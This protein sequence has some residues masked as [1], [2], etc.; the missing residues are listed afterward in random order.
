[1]TREERVAELG[2]LQTIKEATD[3]AIAS[4]GHV[5][6]SCLDANGLG[7]DNVLQGWL[8]DDAVFDA[9]RVEEREGVDRDTKWRGIRLAATLTMPG[10]Y[11]YYPDS[12][13]EIRRAVLLMLAALDDGITEAD[14]TGRID[15]LFNIPYIRMAEIERA[16]RELGSAI[17]QLKADASATAER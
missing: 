8:R 17:E 10:V 16:Y 3:I 15:T 12:V 13:P 1:M 11:S 6:E 7:Y 4:T 2:R 5:G 9:D 14:S